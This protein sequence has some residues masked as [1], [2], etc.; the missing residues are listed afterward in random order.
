MNIVYL[1]GNGFD[2]NINLKTSYTDF[3]KYYK[4]KKSDS[5]AVKAF[6]EEISESLSKWSDLEV[7]FGRYTKNIPSF[8]ELEQ[9]HK[10]IVNELAEYLTKIQESFVSELLPRIDVNRFKRDL[11]QPENYL[12]GRDSNLLKKFYYLKGGNAR[13]YHIVN[14]NYT[15]VLEHMLNLDIDSNQNNSINAVHHEGNAQ[16]KLDSILHIHG[17][18][19][20]DMVLGVDTSD[21][22]INKELSNHL[23]AKQHLV[24]PDCNYVMR[25]GIDLQCENL[26]SEADL[27]C[28]FGSSIGKTDQTW[29]DLIAKQLMSRDCRL[30]IFEH[31][32]G[33]DRRR[34]QT[35]E[36]LRRQILLKFFE[37]NQI[38]KISE[39]VYFSF[40]SQMFTLINDN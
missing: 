24:K 37:S 14:F 4:T 15:H 9:I 30:V 23:D 36:A 40:N 10:S 11:F 17:S 27:I 13:K 18:L 25:H 2:L 26:I 39:K 32:Q 5:P 35:Q 12:K 16:I 29:W 21:Q 34:S 6:K 28:I 3:F 33:F 7:E 8:S 22:I 31:T 38:E 19:D 20:E 1:I